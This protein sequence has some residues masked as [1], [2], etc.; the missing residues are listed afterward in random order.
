MN[1]PPAWCHSEH[2]ILLLA[3][4]CQ[5]L[6]ALAQRRGGQIHQLLSGTAVFE[7]DLH[8]P[9]ARISQRDWSRLL[10]NIQA[11][12]CPELP[13]LL[14]MAMLHNPYIA[15][16][17]ALQAAPTLSRALRLLCFY[18]QQL[19]PAFFPAITRHGDWLEIQLQPGL[20]PHKSETQQ[21]QM[22]LSYLLTLL[23]LQQGHL[24]DVR[25]QLT[26][27]QP[28]VLQLYQQQ[29]DCPITG[30][31]PHN[32]I[33]LALNTLQVQCKAADQ[34]A[35]ANAWRTCRQ[36]QRTLGKQRGV[37]EVLHR[38]QQRALPAVL[39]LETISAQLGVSSSA[40]RRLLAAEHSSF[41]R[42]CDAVRQ[43][44]ACHLLAQQHASSNR[45]LAQQLGYSDEHNFRRAFKRWTGLLPSDFRAWLL[46]DLRG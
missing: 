29:L 38:A 36:L 25:I 26:S 13:F 35:F 32:A 1:T 39:S 43:Q 45:E 5:D 33:W 2:K 6:L 20:S 31:Q 30:G 27:T 12:N 16:S 41:A 28:S 17:Q 37:L 40:L 21:L 24:A 14:G 15:I 4:G 7:T 19:C 42:I 18:R 9:M 44:Q 3:H 10:G 23:K 34:H 11:V 22:V 8:K 46:G